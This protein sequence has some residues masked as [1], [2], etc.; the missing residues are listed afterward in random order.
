MSYYAQFDSA[1]TRDWLGAN[2]EQENEENET[3]YY[4]EPKKVEDL[5]I[6]DFDLYAL[7]WRMFL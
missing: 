7:D 5:E 6:T 2:H 1:D 4:Y 3:G